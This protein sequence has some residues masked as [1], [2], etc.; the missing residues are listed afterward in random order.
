MEKR[1][2]SSS[3]AEHTLRR[4]PWRV[5]A[6]PFENLVSHKYDNKGTE[7]EPIHLIDFLPDDLE[8]PMQYGELRE[9]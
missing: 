8:N 1:D 4:R 9:R 6:E 3:L 2:P 5:T 7:E